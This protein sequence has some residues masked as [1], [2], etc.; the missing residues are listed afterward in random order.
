[1]AMR[2]QIPGTLHPRQAHHGEHR[3]GAEF[4]VGSLMSTGAR[5][6]T[7]I[8]P[9]SLESQQFT[10]GAG[11]GLVKS[12]SQSRL[13]CFQIRATGVPAFGE[14]A[15][16]QCCYL[17]RD[18]DLDGAGRFFLSCERILDRPPAADL[19]ADLDQFLAELLKTAKLGDFLLG[20]SHGSITG[21]GFRNRFAVKLI[22]DAEAR[23]VTGV[24]GLS[25]MTGGLSTTSDR[26]NDGSGAHVVKTGNGL[27]QSATTS[28]QVAQRVG[29]INGLPF[30]KY[31]ILPESGV[32][33]KSRP[34]RLLLCRTPI[35]ARLRF[36]GRKNRY[37]G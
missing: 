7:P 23:T 24:I 28:F 10:Q 8:R 25:A 36:T 33:K 15:A 4:L 1:M 29:H 13:Q 34:I 26:A 11:P 20:F 27:Q 32:K 18:L 37:A 12:R 3:P 21:Q 5:Q 16:Q 19:S 35:R 17:P 22:S 31:Y 9:G 14:D 2:T 6:L 30:W